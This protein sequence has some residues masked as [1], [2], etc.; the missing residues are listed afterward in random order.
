MT[1]ELTVISDNDWSAFQLD[2]IRTQIAKGCSQDEIM[3]F[4]QVC[5]KTGLDPFT[6]QIYAVSR[7]GK[8]TIQVGIDGLRAVAASSGEYNGS[9]TYWCGKD[10][11]WVDVWLDSLPPA[12][13]K[14]EVY[15][16]NSPRP[17]VGVCRFDDYNTNQNLWLKMPSVMIGKCSESQALRKAF[18]QQLT[19][20]Y[21]TEEMGQASISQSPTNPQIEKLRTELKNLTKDWSNDQK[22]DLKEQVGATE[23]WVSEDY[24]LA[25]EIVIA[26]DK[27]ESGQ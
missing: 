4:G 3:L 1:S 11:A 19:G 22:A 21:S 17:F 5:Q 20:L 26:Q 13:A 9:Q 16:G 7:G 18:P 25:I 24:L 2:L 27:E 23:K 14:T 12:A 8:M 15:R 10:G 6:R